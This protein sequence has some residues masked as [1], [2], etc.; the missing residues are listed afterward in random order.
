MDVVRQAQELCKV[1][2][3]ITKDTTIA[4]TTPN[5]TQSITIIVEYIKVAKHQANTIL[6][7]SM[8]AMV[9]ALAQMVVTAILGMFGFG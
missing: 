3:N 7:Q 6:Y 8:A 4:P 9:H 5:I 2:A 1:L